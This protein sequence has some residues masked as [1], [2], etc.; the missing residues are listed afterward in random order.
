MVEAAG[1]V[2]YPVWMPPSLMKMQPRTDPGALI[3]AK[4]AREAAGIDDRR[5][6]PEPCRRQARRRSRVPIPGDSDHSGKARMVEA[7]G[8]EP[9]SESMPQKALQA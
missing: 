7:A 5:K 8:I 1:I 3:R 9:A 6:A 2:Y 4:A